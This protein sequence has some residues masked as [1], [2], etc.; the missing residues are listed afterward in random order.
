[1]GSYYTVVIG[2]A[3]LRGLSTMD[4]VQNK[5]TRKVCEKNITLSSRSHA[6]VYYCIRR[7]SFGSCRNSRNFADTIVIASACDVYYNNA[8][9]DCI[10]YRCT[11]YTSNSFDFVEVFVRARRLRVF[12]VFAEKSAII[13]VV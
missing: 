2:A 3:R 12:D 6:R 4:K 8:L 5:A 11:S 13:Y 10:L 9:Y 7:H 1:M